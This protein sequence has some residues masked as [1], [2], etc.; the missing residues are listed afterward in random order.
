MSLDIAYVIIWFAVV[1][2]A[3]SLWFLILELLLS[4]K[5]INN[6]VVSL[7]C[8][9]SKLDLRN[10]IA[11]VVPAH[12]EE[13]CISRTLKNIC[14]QI[15]E[16]DILVVVAHNCN[17]HTVELSSVYTDEIITVDDSSQIGK[18]Y[19]IAA[20]QNY[21]KDKTFDA[22]VI[23]DADCEISSGLIKQV[24]T[25]A[26]QQQRPVQSIYTLN[27]P[28]IDS[29]YASMSAL[30]FYIKN[31]MRAIG[32]YNITGMAN[33]TGSGFALPNNLFLDYNFD[34]GH[35]VEDMKMGIDFMLIDKAPILDCS[36][37]NSDL[38]RNDVDIHLQRQ[39]WEHGHIQIIAEFVPQFIKKMYK[40]PKLSLL[41]FCIDLVFPP[42]ALY[43]M[44]LFVIEFITIILSIVFDYYLPVLLLFVT[45]IIFVIIFFYAIWW[46][47]QD[48]VLKSL[49]WRLPKYMIRKVPIYLRAMLG[50]YSGWNKT[51]R[52]S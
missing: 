50:N 42:L 35:I 1:L 8:D 29:D 18:S 39:R 36:F 30:A 45:N 48:R 6:S 40:S 14:N 22:V 51:K 52:T 17:D 11:V 19:A 25:K 4:L 46:H 26:V 24:T 44:L 27:F 9:D 23:I 21:L 10:Q 20:A 3:G 37:I 43:F 33:V 32:L 28:N 31:K 49:W 12:N 16:N 47:D 7:N 38:P 13:A 34:H 41:L 2:T 15:D 5:N